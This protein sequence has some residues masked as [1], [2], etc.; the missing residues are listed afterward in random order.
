MKLP[1]VLACL[2]LIFL[3]LPV[4]ASIWFAGIGNDGYTKDVDAIYAALSSLSNL[5]ELESNAFTLADQ[6]GTGITAALMDWAS[7]LSPGDTLFFVYSGHGGYISDS[8]SAPDET[9]TA[10]FASDAWDETIGL[11]DDSDQ[12]T[13]DDLAQIFKAQ[14]F[15]GVT[16]IVIMDACYSGGFIGG[17]SDL[18]SV[19][20]LTFLGSS[21][22]T[23]ESYGWNDALSIFTQGLINGLDNLDADADGDGILL[24]GEWFDF[25]Y[26][27]TTGEVSGQDPVFWGDE[28]L[29]IATAYPVPLPGSFWLLALPGL[30]LLKAHWVK[31]YPNYEKNVSLLGIFFHTVD[32]CMEKEYV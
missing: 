5:E 17:T 23:Q 27:W 21:R 20:N 22:E 11:W 9:G 25:A 26:A 30:I 3:P 6:S 24:A 19:S 13:D 7:L 32:F 8:D 16:T 15:E 28:A 31:N 2:V 12:L 29:V 14:A 4:F 10:S 1:P 18:N